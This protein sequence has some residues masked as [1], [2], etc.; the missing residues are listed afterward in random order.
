VF[1]LLLLVARHGVDAQDFKHLIKLFDT[2]HPPV[3][4]VSINSSEFVLNVAYVLL[5]LFLRRK[6]CLMIRTM[7]GS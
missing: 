4:G 3:V 6:L 7:I 2:E 5:S 1:E